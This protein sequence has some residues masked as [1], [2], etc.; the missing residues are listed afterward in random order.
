MFRT[1]RRSEFLLFAEQKKQLQARKN[2][3]NVACRWTYGPDSHYLINL[4]EYWR[5]HQEE[6][7]ELD[8]RKIWEYCCPPGDKSI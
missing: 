5:K 2:D 4:D 3:Y 6:N 1:G 8:N 7:V